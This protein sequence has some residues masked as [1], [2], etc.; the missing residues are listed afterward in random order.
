M[1]G[2]GNIEYY[3]GI[4]LTFEEQGGGIISNHTSLIILTVIA[5]LMLFNTVMILKFQF[6]G[7]GKGACNKR[8][9]TKYEDMEHEDEISDLTSSSHDEQDNDNS[10]Y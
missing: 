10:S 1:S 6:C 8:Q 3:E 2:D 5:L 9:K 4:G 7:I